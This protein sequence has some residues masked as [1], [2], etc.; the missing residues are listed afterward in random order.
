MSADQKDGP[1][2]CC[3]CGKDFTGDGFNPWPLMSVAKTCCQLC[4]VRRV[5]TE[6][7]RLENV[8][9]DDIPRWN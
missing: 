3:I 2:V 8:R 4:Y 9:R 7:S 1:R 6:R 5:L